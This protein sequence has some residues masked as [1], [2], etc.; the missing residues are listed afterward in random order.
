MNFPSDEQM[1]EAN[2]DSTLKILSERALFVSNERIRTIRNQSNTKDLK[3]TVHY[4]FSRSSSET[5]LDT[6]VG[7]LYITKRR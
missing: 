6:W 3:W 2:K 1:V 4:K 5:D 7:L